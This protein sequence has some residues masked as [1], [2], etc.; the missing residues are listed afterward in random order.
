MAEP[1]ESDAERARIGFAA[2]ITAYLSWGLLPFYLKAVQSVPA[3][4]ILAHRVVWA[5]PF[6]ALIIAFRG[7]WGEVWRALTHRRT[8]LIL[9][10][11]SGLIAINWF[12]YIYAVVIGQVFQG[13]LGYY[14][15]PLMNVAVGVLFFQE[16]LRSMQGAA[17]AF[18][19]AGVAYLTF[20]G[21]QFPWISLVLAVSFTCY[22]A[23]RKQVAI[24]AMP[25]LFIE[26]LV[27]VPVA[28]G[29]LGWLFGQQ[30]AVFLAGDPGLSVLLTLAGPVTVVP[31]LMF[32]LAA[33]RLQLTTIGILQFMSPTIQFFIGV[34]YGEPLTTA[35]MVCFACIWVA[36][37]LFAWDAWSQSR[38][39]Q[40]LRAGRLV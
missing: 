13:S 11:T 3:I 21:G 17:V 18:A 20:S 6:G 36:I 27:L 37:S 28:L 25:G 8:L 32:A 22:A 38:K 19:A 26:T 31:L 33:R 29:Y 10:A 39:I 9:I 40:A 23:I 35:H 30:S 1:L 34:Y 12:V 2:A 16:R 7:Q 5:I 14:I 4:E 15:N 24:G